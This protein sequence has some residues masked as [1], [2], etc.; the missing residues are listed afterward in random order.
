MSSVLTISYN[1]NLKIK[2][3][4]IAIVVVFNICFGVDPHGEPLLRKR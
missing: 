1:S 3:L 2:D 4:A